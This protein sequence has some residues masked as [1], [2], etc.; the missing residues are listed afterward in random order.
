MYPFD[1]D[2]HLVVSQCDHPI[3]VREN[4]KPIPRTLIT[5]SCI[6]CI[7]IRSS[8]VADSLALTV[9]LKFY[10]QDIL[11]NEKVGNGVITFLNP[12]RVIYTH[13]L[14]ITDRLV[15]HCHSKF[16]RHVSTIIT[17]PH[18]DCLSSQQIISTF[19]FSF[20]I[21]CSTPR[22]HSANCCRW[23]QPSINPTIDWAWSDRAALFSS[24]K[25][26]L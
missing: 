10:L 11:S 17:N 13:S 14:N 25:I 15:T 9:N 26:P 23:F 3:P 8:D 1:Q 2:V 19:W 20:S 12:S 24:G 5:D 4:D 16:S 6:I 7:Q 22:G 21:Y 18:T